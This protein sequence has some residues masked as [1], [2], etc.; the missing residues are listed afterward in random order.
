MGC[1][2]RIYTADFIRVSGCD[3]PPKEHG[4]A[5]SMGDNQPG[6]STVKEKRQRAQIVNGLLT[7]RPSP[8]PLQR[9]SSRQPSAYLLHLQRP[10]PASPSRMST[11]LSGMLNIGICPLGSRTVFTTPSPDATIP[12]CTSGSIHLSN[13]HSRYVVGMWRQAGY[14]SG[15]AKA[16]R[17]E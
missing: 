13:S 11:N 16:V 3:A 4:K 6:N 17:S 2:R 7:T 14:L 12:L 15:V 1:S 10:S 5:K 8:L 9:R